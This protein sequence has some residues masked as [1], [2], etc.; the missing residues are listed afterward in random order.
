MKRKMSCWYVI[1]TRENKYFG[2]ISTEHKFVKLDKSVVIIG[3][4]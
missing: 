1:N 4:N 2:L 3:I